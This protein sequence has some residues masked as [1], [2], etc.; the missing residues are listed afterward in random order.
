MLGAWYGDRYIPVV[1]VGRRQLGSRATDTK[2]PGYN[3]GHKKPLYTIACHSFIIGI[4]HPVC[5]NVALLL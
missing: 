5:G 2:N 4:V 1:K 3:S